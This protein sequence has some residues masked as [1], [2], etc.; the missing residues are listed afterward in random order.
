LYQHGTGLP[1]QFYDEDYFGGKIS[2]IC[3]FN[4]DMNKKFFALWMNASNKP[5][6]IDITSLF[7]DDATGEFIKKS[8]LT[9][10]DFE[11]REGYQISPVKLETDSNGSNDGDTGQIEGIWARFDITFPKSKKTN[12][13]ELIVH[14]RDSFRTFTN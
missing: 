2:L 6:R 14:I 10:A 9:G 11:T 8:Y 5:E 1:A 12:L 13:Y 3:N 7:R 4:R